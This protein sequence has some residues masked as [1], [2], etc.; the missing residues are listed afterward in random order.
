[1]SN[2]AIYSEIAKNPISD[3]MLGQLIVDN[4]P[5]SA[6]IKNKDLMYVHCNSRLTEDFGHKLTR[7]MLGKLDH[8][9]PW[10]RYT[11]SYQI[12]DTE[13]LANHNAIEF[14]HLIQL[15]NNKHM[16][17]STKKAELKN[18]L[19]E[20]F[21]VLGIVK[22]LWPSAQH[23]LRLI[24]DIDY[25]LTGKE[26]D[27]NQYIFY[28][29]SIPAENLTKKELTCLFYLLR[30]VNTKD[31]AKLLLISA[32]TV[33]THIENIKFKLNCSTKS[34]LINK[35]IEKNLLRLIPKDIKIQDILLVTA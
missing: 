9:L 1:M 22:L 25:S 19:G 11:K 12:A 21:G 8:E 16:V 27:N 32:R 28:E 34:D 33:E 15:E 26:N 29:N 18:S 23:A 24:M 5:Q 4:L 30:G 14:V 17:M 31:V 35:A 7:R 13:V 2:K 20:C 6:W 10:E 3:E